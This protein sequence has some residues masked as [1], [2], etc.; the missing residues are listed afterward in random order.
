MFYFGTIGSFTI[1][2]IEDGSL[3]S[4]NLLLKGHAKIWLIIDP[5][6]S[7]KLSKKLKELLGC[8]CEQILF[9][10]KPGHLIHPDRLTEWG[11][12]YEIFVQEPNDLVMIKN[13]VTHMVINVGCNVAVSLNYATKDDAYSGKKLLCSCRNVGR[14]DVIAAKDYGCYLHGCESIEINSKEEYQQHLEKFHE[15]KE[16]FPCFD[17]ACDKT[18]SRV[19]DSER[20]FKEV[21]EKVKVKCPQSG[22]Q[23]LVGTRYLN[24]HLK[25]YH[26]IE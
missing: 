23:S 25:V 21:H 14:M 3:K 2:H 12:D 11:I 9:H 7:L 20:H 10:K 17:S 8:S 15:N 6:N 4:V 22:C 24:H 19:D 26:S 5:S 13:N 16:K 1:L 18:F